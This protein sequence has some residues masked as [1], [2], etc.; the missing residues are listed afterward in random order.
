VQPDSSDSSDGP[1]ATYA[2]VTVQPDA[3]VTVTPEISLDVPYAEFV[4]SGRTGLTPESDLLQP[5]RP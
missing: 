1:R 4:D 5:G 2:V 3:T